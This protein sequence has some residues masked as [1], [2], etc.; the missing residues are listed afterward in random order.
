MHLLLL[1]CACRSDPAQAPSTDDDDGGPAASTGTGT[2]STSGSTT[3]GD[4][5]PCEGSGDCDA[6]T[7]HCVAPYDGGLGEIGA[8]SCVE[9]CLEAGDLARACIDDDSC[10]SGLSCN[11]VDGFC[12]SDADDETTSSTGTGTGTGTETGTT[13]TGTGTSGASSS[14][15]TTS[16]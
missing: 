6:A 3:L 10:C 7:P 8:A 1:V 13:S 4:A 15:G 12:A 5:A 11:P 14:S 2:G 16:G 9:R